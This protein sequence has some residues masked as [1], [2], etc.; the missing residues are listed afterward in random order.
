LQSRS[1][2]L[3]IPAAI[4]DRGNDEHNRFNHVENF[5]RLDAIMAPYSTAKL[6]MMASQILLSNKTDGTCCQ[7]KTDW[8]IANN[9]GTARPCQLQTQ[10]R[11]QTQPY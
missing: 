11:F 2:Y 5:R 6:T 7:A 4:A 9:G 8:K 10:R 1:F 3:E